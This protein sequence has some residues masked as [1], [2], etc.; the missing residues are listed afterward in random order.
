MTKN[1][2]GKNNPN[3]GNFKIKKWNYVIKEYQTGRSLKSIADEFSVTQD[4]I[5]RIL[6]RKQIKIRNKGEQ[7]KQESTRKQCSLSAS[8]EKPWLKGREGFWKGKKRPEHSKLMKGK[9]YGKKIIKKCKI[10]TKE[11]Q[12]YQSQKNFRTTCASEFCGKKGRGTQLEKHHNWKGGTSLIKYPPE[13]N[14]YL[15]EEIRKRD[16]FTCQLCFGEQNKTRL[17]VHHIDYNKN[18]NR[19]SNLISLCHVCHVNTNWNRKYWERV[20]QKL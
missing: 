15:K 8:R 20:I 13:F 16:N 2:N 17:D 1:I 11:F 18:N 7:M 5:K 6:L 3:Y 19:K 14:K 4:T 10:C 12:I 9:D